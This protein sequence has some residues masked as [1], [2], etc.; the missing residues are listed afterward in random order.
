MKIPF[1]ERELE[2]VGRYDAGNTQRPSWDRLNTPITIRENYLRYMRGEDPLWMPVQA[3]IRVIAPSEIRDNVARGCSAEFPTFDPAVSGGGKDMFGVD[4]IFVPSAGGSMIEEGNPK[5]PD[6]DHWEDYVQLPDLDALDWE[7]IGARNREL[8]SDGRVNSLL[9]LSGLFERLMSFV[10][11]AD[12]LVAMIDED[13]QDAVKRLFE[14]L[15]GYYEKM[16]ILGK[17]YLDLDQ[18]TFHDDWGSARAPLFSLEL[19]RE[20]IVPYLKRLVECAHRNG[21]IFE[22]HSCGMNEQM[23]PAMIECGVDLW[24][25][26]PLNDKFMLYEKYGDQLILGIESIDLKADPADEAAAEA[27]IMKLIDMYKTTGKRLIP[28]YPLPSKTRADIYR[29]SRIAFAE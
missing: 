10:D 19:C 14:Y 15:V 8:L 22:L 17:K 7:E 16:F 3:D 20:M 18:I 25:G 11:M 5:V 28:S 13:S 2:V 1:D 26:Q 12:A 9:V 27:Y 6:L 4:W 21:M 24:C 23:V 29:L